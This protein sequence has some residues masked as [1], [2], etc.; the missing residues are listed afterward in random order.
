MNVRAVAVHGI[1]VSGGQVVW[2]LVY[3]LAY[4]GFVI[5]LTCALFER[6]NLP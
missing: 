1:A 5:A 2:T 4:S 6:R 3:A